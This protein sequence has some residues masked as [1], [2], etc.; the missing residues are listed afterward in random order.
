MSLPNIVSVTG[1]RPRRSYNICPARSSIQT[2]GTALSKPRTTADQDERIV[3]TIRR[4]QAR[5]RAFIR[6]RIADDQDVEDIL[7]EVFSELVEAYRLV[8]PIEEVGRWL[9]R[10]ARNRIIDRF[11]KERLATVSLE[12]PTADS[13]ECVRWEDLLPSPDAGPEAQYA[14]QILLDEL[15]AA[16]DELPGDQRELFLAHEVDGRSF[17][18]L[19]AETGVSINTLLSRKHYAVMY[20]RRRLQAIYHE[21]QRTRG[22]HR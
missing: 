5:L 20:L 18:E 8:K 19:A 6:R 14:R 9:V 12:A 2:E 16:L 1:P 15:A 10:V 21:F 4:E 13:A 17:K 3:D 22:S 11:R 7:Q